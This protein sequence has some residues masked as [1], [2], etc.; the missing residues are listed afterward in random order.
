MS[1]FPGSAFRWFHFDAFTMPRRP[2]HP[3]LRA[4]VGSI[5]IVVLLGLLLVGLVVGAAMLAAGALWQTWTRRRAP[6]APDLRAEPIDG[7][8]R[9]VGKPGLPLAH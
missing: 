6:R 9:V 4:I 3:V 2:R 5:G 7:S 1:T 8:C